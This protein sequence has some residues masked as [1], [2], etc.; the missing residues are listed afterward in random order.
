M[1][2]QDNITA[3][4]KPSIAIRHDYNS[5]SK[6]CH[7]TQ[8]PV[9]VIKNGEAD[10]VVMS[11]EAYQKMMARQRLGRMLSEVDCEIAAGTPMRDFEE[12]FAAIKKSIDN[13]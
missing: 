5:F 1:S 8:S 3:N 6:I 12:T 7:E 11:C 2:R 10:L 9:I 13:A 4:I